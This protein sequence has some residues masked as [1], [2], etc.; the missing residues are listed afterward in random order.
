ML[1]T[2]SWAPSPTLDMWDYG[3]TLTCVMPREDS[4]QHM[5]SPVSKCQDPQKR[6]LRPPE[7]PSDVALHSA[8]RSV[9]T[10]T[11]ISV[12]AERR[13]Q[14]P[15]TPS[16]QPRQ[17]GALSRTGDVLRYLRTAGVDRP[18]AGVAAQ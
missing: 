5:G 12:G 6:R 2:W 14:A 7:V 8:R 15:A 3:V 9:G 13:S 10:N 17:Q 4:K 1:R 18:R 16:R 11:P